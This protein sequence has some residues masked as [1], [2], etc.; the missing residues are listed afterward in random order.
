MTTDSPIPENIPGKLAYPDWNE[1]STWCLTGTFGP[2][3]G[4]NRFEAARNFDSPDS[5]RRYYSELYGE[6]V[7]AFVSSH[8][9]TGGGRWGFRFRGKRP[10]NVPTGK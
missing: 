9:K 8:E 10:T 3:E 5:A 1:A 2:C 4:R 7:D 6:V